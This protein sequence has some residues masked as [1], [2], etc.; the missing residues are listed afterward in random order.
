MHAAIGGD[1]A[2][3][4]QILSVITVKKEKKTKEH[5]MQTLHVDN[6]TRLMDLVS[7]VLKYN[8]SNKYS[9][10]KLIKKQNKK[11]KTFKV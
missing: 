1:G 6:V 3:I 11:R 10:I 4:S 5:Q 9:E 7:L 8:I 2:K